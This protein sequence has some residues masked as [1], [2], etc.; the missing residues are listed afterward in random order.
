MYAYKM[1]HSTKIGL[2]LSQLQQLPPYTS[3]PGPGGAEGSA[4][5]SNGASPMA[6]ASHTATPPNTTSTPAAPKDGRSAAQPDFPTP[7]PSQ[8]Q[9]HGAPV[10]QYLNENVAPYFLEVSKYLAAHR[11]ALESRVYGLTMYAD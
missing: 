2:T 7:L 11:Y 5:I 9:A 6:T 10:R 1:Q 4:P 3:A 8:A